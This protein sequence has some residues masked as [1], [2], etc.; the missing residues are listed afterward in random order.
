MLYIGIDPGESWCGFA[1]LETTSDGV[2][3]VESRSYDVENHHGYVGMTRDIIDLLP[4]AKRT[5]IVAED[6]RIRRSGH[7]SFSTGNTLRF[8]GALEYA[9]SD[10]KTFSFSTI[11]PSDKVENLTRE[12][13]GRVLFNYRNHWPKARHSSWRHCLSAWRVLGQ[14]LMNQDRA[15]LEILHKKKKS[16]PCPQWLPVIQ[17]VGRDRVAEAAWWIRP[18]A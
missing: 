12:L 2:I 6:F 14:Y 10:V 1:A 4:H 9:A 15:V 5:H 7:Q 8:L 11:P 16:H 3:R 18:K 13:F 17:R